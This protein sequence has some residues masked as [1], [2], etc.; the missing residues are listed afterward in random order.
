MEGTYPERDARARAAVAGVGWAYLAAMSR[1]DWVRA[2]QLLSLFQSMYRDERLAV[3]AGFEAN[4]GAVGEGTLTFARALQ[5]AV[6]GRFDASTRDALKIAFIA[7]LG[8]VD[9]VAIPLD[10]MPTDANALGG[11]F[12]TQFRQLQ[13]N[14]TGLWRFDQWS[15]SAGGMDVASAVGGQAHG[16]IEGIDDPTTTAAANASAAMQASLWAL[17]A[18]KG[19]AAPVSSPPTAD[20]AGGDVIAIDEAQLVTATKPKMAL[21]DVALWVLGI[22]L[23]AV[24]GGVLLYPAYKKARRLRAH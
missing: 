9:A 21:G 6:S 20:N 2:S 13:P 18:S 14:G 23:V 22:G 16:F 1:S 15:L 3:L 10:M 5:P 12:Q 19:S 8:G 17:L 11:W 7:Q 24:A 4:I